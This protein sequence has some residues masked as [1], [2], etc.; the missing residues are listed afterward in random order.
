MLCKDLHLLVRERR[1]NIQ[2]TKVSVNNRTMGNNEY[3][4]ERERER[5]SGGVADVV[6]LRFVFFCSFVSFCIFFF[7][8]FLFF[9]CFFFVC[10]VFVP[11]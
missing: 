5:E 8:V 3:E 2:E 6:H 10:L 7:F 1:E 4:R 9:L 11:R